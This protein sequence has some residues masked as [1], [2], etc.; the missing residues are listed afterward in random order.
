MGSLVAPGVAGSGDL[1][2]VGGVEAASLA[3][4]RETV[5]ASAGGAGELSVPVRGDLSAFDPGDYDVIIDF[6]VPAQA[7]ACARTAADLGKGAVIGTTGLPADAAGKLREAAARA[8]IVLAPNASLGMNAVFGVLGHLAT[9]LGGGFDVEVVETHHAGKRDAPSGTA[10]RLAE[11]VCRSRG[12]DHRERV[13]L[14][15][16]PP[17]GARRAGEVAIHSVRGGA[18]VG[19]HEVRFI[20]AL[21]E[22]RI[23]HEA[24]SREAFVSGALAAARFVAG[25]PAGLYDMLDVLGLAPGGGPEP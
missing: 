5:R 2:L 13:S 9:A 20:S 3:G 22:V 15:R 18:V 14:G 6:S 11:I 17:G 21:E 23:A 12:M 4:G 24:F 10:A 1:S 7:L 16:T 19:Q 25:A 8:A